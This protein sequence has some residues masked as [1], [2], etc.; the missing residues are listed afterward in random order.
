MMYG[1]VIAIKNKTQLRLL[2]QREIFGPSE[3]TISCT[4]RIHRQKEI[5]VQNSK[6]LLNS[7]KLQTLKHSTP[8]G[9]STARH[10]YL[11]WIRQ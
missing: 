4:C 11:R 3:V 8:W 5:D 10:G 2:A 7:S 9:R 6:C 1:F